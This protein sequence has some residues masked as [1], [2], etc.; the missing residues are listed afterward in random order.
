ME[1][2]PMRNSR[3]FW[4]N[5]AALIVT[6][7]VNALG[8]GQIIPMEWAAPGLAVLNIILRPFTKQPISGI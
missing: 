1:A 6:T 2:K 4:L 3:T 7:V 5:F 8:E